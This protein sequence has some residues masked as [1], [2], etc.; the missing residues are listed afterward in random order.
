MFQRWCPLRCI[1]TTRIQIGILAALLSS[2]ASA[3]ALPSL[4]KE[5]EA[6]YAKAVT[7]SANFS[8]VNFEAALGKKKTSTGTILVKRPSKIRWETL[9]PDPNLL[10][11]DGTHFWFYTPPFDEGERGQIIERSSSEV[12]SK[13][14][15]A[16]LAGSFSVAR[17]MKMIP[18]PNSTF[19]LIPKPGSAGTV[20]QAEIQINPKDQLI[21]KV[22]L[23][24]QGGN[25]AEISLT[26]IELGKPLKDELFV[27]KAPPNTDSIDE[28]R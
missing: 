26:Q 12:Q 8:Q 23:D 17:D 15:H 10:V 4:L 9:K 1:K 14:A 19:V 18:K 3:S 6:K 13:L 16:L 27:F 11:S 21:Q 22:C 7:L 24:H 2:T 25:R 28:V 5:V 20:T